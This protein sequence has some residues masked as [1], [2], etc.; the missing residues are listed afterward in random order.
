M[1]TVV[2]VNFTR[3]LFGEMAEANSSGVYNEWD[4]PLNTSQM[5]KLPCQLTVSHKQ[6]NL[7]ALC[8]CMPRGIISF[9][10]FLSPSFSLTHKI[11]IPT[12]LPPSLPIHTPIA[13]KKSR[14]RN[15]ARRK[16]SN[17]SYSLLH[18]I[19]ENLNLKLQ[20]SKC[21]FITNKELIAAH[22]KRRVRKSLHIP[23][24]LHCTWAIYSSVR[25]ICK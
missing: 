5:I 12:K 7:G 20:S 15:K 19:N 8:V 13:L 11:N 4:S 23:S 17:R 3:I 24:C 9:F 1:G 21:V 2:L 22:S 18:L 25:L 10:L 14:A 16:P 6:N